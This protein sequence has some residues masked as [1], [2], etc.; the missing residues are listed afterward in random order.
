MSDTHRESKEKKQRGSI[1]PRWRRELREWSKS[2]F[3][4]IVF[5]YFFT[6]FV[7]K[8]Y[9]VEGT[10][11]QP[12]LQDGERI[13]V[14]R[15]IYMTDELPLIKQ[16]LPLT[17]APE[18]GDV[19][20]FWFPREPSKYFIKRVIGIPGDVV[21]VRNGLIEVN[22]RRVNTA[23]IADKYLDQKSRPS[24]TVPPG[25]YYVVGDHHAKS[26][27]SRDWGLVPAKY[28]IGKAFVRYWPL[29]KIGAIRYSDNPPFFVP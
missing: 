11:M 9:K 18:H 1:E 17:R 28:I 10:S 3:Y 16:E 21:S 27:D 13:F 6:T 19:V 5:V 8:A 25:Y 15:Y 12:L 14:N 24:T 23:F 22:G 26:Y 20:V 4:G 7:F 29:S 2:L